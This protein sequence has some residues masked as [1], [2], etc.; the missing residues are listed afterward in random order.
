MYS[1][2]NESRPNHTV[3]ELCRIPMADQLQ[4]PRSTLRRKLAK[5]AGIPA[6]VHTPVQSLDTDA[7]HSVSTGAGHEVDTAAVQRIDGLEDEV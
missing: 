5:H 2:A 6:P 3:G 1:K 7:V 4:I